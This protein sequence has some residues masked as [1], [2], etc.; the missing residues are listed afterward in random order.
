MVVKKD[1]LELVEVIIYHVLMLMMKVF[2]LEIYSN[3][4]SVVVQVMY[5][6]FC[7]T[8]VLGRR[9][10]FYWAFTSSNYSFR[11]VNR[12]FYVAL[13]SSM[14]FALLVWVV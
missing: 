6:F 2:G 12:D 9:I 4:K 8:I 3:V 5:M 14:I 1:L 7:L 11:S 13:G 10:C